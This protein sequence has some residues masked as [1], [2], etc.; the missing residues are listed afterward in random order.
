[1]TIIKF[2]SKLPKAEGFDRARAELSR[3]F[4]N[5]A[6]LAAARAAEV[7]NSENPGELAAIVTDALSDATSAT[8]GWTTVRNNLRDSWGV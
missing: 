2:P 6:G 3:L 1:M 5:M 4:E 7:R 8:T